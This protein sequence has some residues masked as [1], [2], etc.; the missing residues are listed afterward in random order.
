MT[1]F[2]TKT[3]FLTLLLFLPFC[4]IAKVQV[5]LVPEM[6]FC[7]FRD[8]RGLIWLGTEKGLKL[9]QSDHLVSFQFPQ[10]SVHHIAPG[11]IY[12]IQEDEA[13]FIWAASYTKGITVFNPLSNQY[14]Q[15]PDTGCLR[16]RSIISMQRISGGMQINTDR[17]AIQCNRKNF[18]CVI[19]PMNMQNPNV[20]LSK[21][22]QGVD[23]W[24][25]NSEGVLGARRV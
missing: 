22:F 5:N 18:Q 1:Q 2:I 20:L 10:D 12:A 14:R 16:N 13:G 23:Y 15:I 6:V 24:L 9:Y 25:I 19:W 7:T 17:G 8:S 4:V 11:L 21:N 3:P